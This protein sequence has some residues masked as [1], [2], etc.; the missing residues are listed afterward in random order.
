VTEARKL[1]IGGPALTP[2]LLSRVAELTDWASVPA[3][4]ALIVNDAATAAG[5]AVLLATGRGT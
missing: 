2:W 1:A 5:L 4:A 3:N